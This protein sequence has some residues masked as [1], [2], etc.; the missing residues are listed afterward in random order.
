MTA[1]SQ[2]NEIIGSTF[3]ALRAGMKQASNAAPASSA[4]TTAKVS[5]SKVSRRNQ[6]RWKR[7][8]PMRRFSFF[9]GVVVNDMYDSS[10]HYLLAP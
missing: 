2:R 5:G 9:Q 7:R 8:I 3:V 6:A 4:G 1:Y 10:E